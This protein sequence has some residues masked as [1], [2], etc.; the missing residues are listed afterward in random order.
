V[1]AGVTVDR[2]TRVDEDFR[3]IRQYGL[4]KPRGGTTADNYSFDLEGWAIGRHS[5]L[6]GIDLLMDDTRLWHVPARVERPDVAARYDVPAEESRF[7]FYAPV[8]CLRFPTEFECVLAAVVADGNRMHIATIEGSRAPLVSSFEPQLSPL[9]VSTL[10]RTGSSMFVRMLGAHPEVV[11]YRPLEYEPRVADYWMETFLSLSEPGSYL[12]Q[13]DP[14]LALEADPRWWLGDEG[15]AP[16]KTTYRINEPELALWMGRDNLGDMAS[17]FQGRIEAVYERIAA[18]QRKRPRYFTEKLVP[19]NTPALMWELY[20]HVREVF[21]VRDFRDMVSSMLAFNVKRGGQ[22][23]LGRDLATTDVDYVLEQVRNGVLRLVKAWQR[24][25]GRAHVVR[26]E[27]LLLNADETL[28][29]LLDY[30]ELDAAPDILDAMRKAMRT[31]SSHAEQHRTTRSA[32]S[33]IGRWRTDLHPD[34]QAACQQSLGF[35]LD[36]FGYPL[37]EVV[38]A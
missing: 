24:R 16:R 15:A 6:A 8:N 23:L 22:E 12:N 21:L 18:L 1:P 29:G 3:F 17:Q 4:E 32:E 2:V 13:L 11:A 33:S 38:P 20:P 31:D 25:G 10:G 7:G 34:L 5:P 30:L 26:Y 9:M 28:E 19:N 14:P 35:A 37:E 27:D 36:A